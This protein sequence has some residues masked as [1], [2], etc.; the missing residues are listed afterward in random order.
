MN[1]GYHS[2]DGIVKDNDNGK[3]IEKDQ[4]RHKDKNAGELVLLLYDRGSSSPRA[5]IYNGSG[6]RGSGWW[7]ADRDNHWVQLLC[8]MCLWFPVVQVPRWPKFPDGPSSYI[9]PLPPCTPYVLLSSIGS[10]RVGAP[11]DSK[12]VPLDPLEPPGRPRDSLRPLSKG[13]GEIVRE[14]RK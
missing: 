12:D 14:D 10:S 3:Y 8:N 13:R 5:F 1:L 2:I 4:D 6:P 11:F 7:H 9:P